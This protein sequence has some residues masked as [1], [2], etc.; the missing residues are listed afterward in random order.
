VLNDLNIKISKK[1]NNYNNP[2]Q[3]QIAPIK[4]K[5]HAKY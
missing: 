4:K 1:K 5:M 3:E 2:K